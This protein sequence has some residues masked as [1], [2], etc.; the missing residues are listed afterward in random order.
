MKTLA[1][2]L[3]LFCANSFAEPLK[4]FEAL[5]SQCRQSFEN[6]SVVEVDFVERN[7][8]WVKRVWSP[9]KST[10]DVKRTDSLVSPFSAF[11]ELTDSAAFGT[12]P[13][14]LAAN[15]LDV[16]ADGKG[17]MQIRRLD[18]AY[19]DRAWVLT[20]GRSSIAFRRVAGG[21]FVPD[22]YT[23]LTRDQVLKGTGPIARCFSL[24]R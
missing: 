23:D 22:G 8:N 7:K 1:V 21:P 18:F 13:D 11:L 24:G 16:P 9:M 19:Q 2:V 10:Y 5:V 14:A 4:D 12:A 6:R 15:D 20:G 17:I 3:V